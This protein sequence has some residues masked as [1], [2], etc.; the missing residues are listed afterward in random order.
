MMD[1]EFCPL[2]FFMETGLSY[3]I[4]DNCLHLREKWLEMYN[5]LRTGIFFL[6][7]FYSTFK[8]TQSQSRV[9]P[10][11]FKTVGNGRKESVTTYL[12]LLFLCANWFLEIYTKN[13]PY[14]LMGFLLQVIGNQGVLRSTVTLSSKT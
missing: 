12:Y 7:N 14:T 11:S 1:F 2:P 8:K 9:S 5:V 6:N 3:I 10:H 4:F 13:K